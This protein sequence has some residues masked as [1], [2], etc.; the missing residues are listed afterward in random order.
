MLARLARFTRLIGEYYLAQGAVKALNLVAIVLVIRLMPVEDYALYTLVM[1]AWVILAIFADLGTGGS[2]VYLRRVSLEERWDLN[3]GITLVRRLRHWFFWGSMIVGLPVTAALA[4]AKGFD[5]F[6]V[7]V[8]ALLLL[9]A[10]WVNLEGVV[11]LVVLRL[12]SQFR[13]F[14]LAEFSGAAFKVFCLGAILFTGLELG[15]ETGLAITAGAL[16]LTSLLARSEVGSDGAQPS[17]GALRDRLFSY[18]R[19]LVPNVIFTALHGQLIIWL[20]ALFGTTSALAE[21][22]A[23]TRYQM[24]LAF[25]G[26]FFGQ[27]AVAKLAKVLD[28]SIFLRQVMAYA[29]LLLVLVSGITSLAY[30]FPDALLA[31]LGPNYGGLD[32][33]LQL[34]AL[35]GAITVVAQFLSLL[36][37]ARGWVRWMSLYIPIALLAIA[38]FLIVFDVS[39][40]VGVLE[41]GL[42]ASVVLLLFELTIF[43]AGASRPDSVSM[44][45]ANCGGNTDNQ[46]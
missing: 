46:G 4:I 44:P 23:V 37:Q 36:N 34:V 43:V 33:E 24:I 39:T 6:T 2:L 21:T 27:V 30:A 11:R 18:L 7:M 20:I 26:G 1:S 40:T 25:V 35:A 28:P 29:G 15:V 10:C 5:A 41:L 45:S 38:L 14:Y 3:A 22:G 19:P 42:G 32:M 31:L 16:L 9:V 13:R 17:P 8:C 12:G